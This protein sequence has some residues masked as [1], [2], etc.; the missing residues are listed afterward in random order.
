MGVLTREALTKGDDIE[1]ELTIP[2]DNVPVLLEGEIAWASD[3]MAGDQH[4]GGIRVKKMDNNDRGRILEYIY[5]KWMT[6]AEDV[7]KK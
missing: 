7:I 2:G 6:S 5:K 3:P 4:K 1:I